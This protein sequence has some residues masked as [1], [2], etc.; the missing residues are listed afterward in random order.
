MDRGAPKAKNRDNFLISHQ[1]IPVTVKLRPRELKI[2]VGTKLFVPDNDAPAII[3]IP[4]PKDSSALRACEAGTRGARPGR[5][6]RG[7]RATFCPASLLDHRYHRDFDAHFNVL[8]SE[9]EA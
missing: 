6:R 2:L 7:R 5:A 1:Q 4:P 3:T 9:R 8:T